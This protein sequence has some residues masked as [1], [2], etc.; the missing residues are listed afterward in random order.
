[1]HVKVFK[2]TNKT[3][4]LTQLKR[5]YKIVIAQLSALV[6]VISVEKLILFFANNFPFESFS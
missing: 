1:M 2:E 3:K 4:R 5:K 6:S